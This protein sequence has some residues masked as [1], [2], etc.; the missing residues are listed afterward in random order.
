MDKVCKK[1]I[2]IKCYIAR[3]VM[4]CTLLCIS[5]SFH[6]NSLRRRESLVSP[7]MLCHDMMRAL[8]QGS[9][10]SN[11]QTVRPDLSYLYNP[12]TF[13]LVS[14][15]ILN[16]S[17]SIT[18]LFISFH[19]TFSCTQSHAFTMPWCTL[20][21]FYMYT[22]IIILNDNYGMPPHTLCE[23]KSHAYVICFMN[24]SE[25]IWSGQIRNIPY[26]HHLQLFHIHINDQK[27]RQVINWII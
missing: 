17:Q 3:Y 16:S 22:N 10:D 9:P 5:G 26:T 25:L 2:N 23:I 7:L 19:I 4:K 6:F 24:L 15:V 12:W 27:I 8:H 13:A 14:M 20:N 1:N 11:P 21:L 18:F